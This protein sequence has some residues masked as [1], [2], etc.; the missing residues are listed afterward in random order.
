[1]VYLNREKAQ[2]RLTTKTAKTTKRE[3]LIHFMVCSVSAAPTR[4][5]G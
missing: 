2:E 5:L 4:D 1:M 3:F